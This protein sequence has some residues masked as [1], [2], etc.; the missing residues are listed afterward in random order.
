[1]S[2]AHCDVGQQGN[3]WFLAG[4]FGSSKIQRSCVIP[5][6]K[7]IFFPVVNMVYYPRKENNGYTCEQ[8]KV[9]A[10]VNNDKAL[11]LHVE[12]D[13]IA[14]KN[15]KRF[16]AR[17]EKCFNIFE[18]IPRE[19]QPYNAYPSASDGYWIGL[20]PL[21]KGKHTLRFGGRY[22]STDSV[23]GRMVQDIEYEITVE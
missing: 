18:K 5:A 8:A 4:G 13:G 20:R 11:D 17:T 14:V 3:I 19:Y 23:Y 9:N 10:A 22:N 12:L 21:Q 6:G 15:P 2:G 7:Y 16:R 1:I